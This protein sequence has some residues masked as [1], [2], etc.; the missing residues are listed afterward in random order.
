MKVCAISSYNYKQKNLKHSQ[1]PSF[2]GKLQLKETA[3]KAITKKNIF[4]FALLS[5]L[6]TKVLSFSEIDTPELISELPVYIMSGAF[7]ITESSNKLEENIEF[8]KAET[9]EDAKKFAEEK[10][11]IKKFKINDLEYANW[12]NEGLTNI[13]NRFKGEVYFPQK[14]KFHFCDR[15]GALA[16]YGV[17][18]DTIRINRKRIEERVSDLDNLLKVNSYEELTKYNLGKG[19]E[20]FCIKLSTAYT[21]PESLTFFEKYS[22]VGSIYK[23]KQRLKQLDNKNPSEINTNSINMYGNIYQNEFETIYHEVGHCFDFKSK[24]LIDIYTDRI[25]SQKD[26]KHLVLPRYHKKIPLSL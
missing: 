15:K 21:N 3:N 14:I 2:E 25:K 22:L 12:I 16:D 13:S 26:L 1:E 17:A 6:I 11:G 5:Y 9:I 7:C 24:T 19:Y 8:K 20:D 4:N 23:V 10:L 18:F